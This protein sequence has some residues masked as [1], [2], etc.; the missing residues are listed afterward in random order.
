VQECFSY[1]GY[2]PGDFK[3]AEE[4]SSKIM[5]LPMNA[6]LTGEEQEYVAKI[7]CEFGD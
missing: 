1:L 2:G 5:S 6:F 3:V 4:V 7:I